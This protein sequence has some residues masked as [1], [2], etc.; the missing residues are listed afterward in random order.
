MDVKPAINI[1][2][3]PELKGTPHI[4][5]A[6]R[7]A[8][9]KRAAS[10]GYSG[11]EFFPGNSA[12]IP[13]NE[14]IN[15]TE[16]NNLKVCAFGTG[17]GKALYGLSL[18]HHDAEIRKLAVNY[19]EQIISVASLFQSSVV[20]GSLQG[21]YLHNIGREQTIEWLCESLNELT[22]IA[23]KKHITVLL[24]PINRYESNLINRL[25]QGIDILNRINSGNLKLLADLFHMNIEEK[26]ID[27]AILQAG[28]YIGHIHFADSNRLYPGFGHID[29]QSVFNVLKKNH[30]KGYLS[31]EAITTDT[32]KDLKKAINVFKSYV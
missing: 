4:Q 27:D 20:I 32:E 15:A 18:T 30:Y 25:E 10:L 12:T 11:V 9:Y 28:P 2:L 13:V 24:E 5:I 23:D 8:I 26:S 14:I 7:E 21:S 1:S 6:N 17:G 31:V 16:S 22:E 19:V 29:F 3:V